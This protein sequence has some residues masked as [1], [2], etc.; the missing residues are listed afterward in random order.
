MERPALNI[1]IA[2]SDE[3]GAYLLHKGADPNLA[4]RTGHPA[5]HRQPVGFTEAVGWLLKAG[6]KVNQDNRRGETPLIVA[7]NR[8]QL[9]VVRLLLDAGANPDITDSAAGYSARDYARRDT[10]SRQILQLIESKKPKPVSA[11]R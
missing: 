9:P 1:T 2:R 6:G 4:A 10:R 5:D 8:R 7:V 3:S 11:A